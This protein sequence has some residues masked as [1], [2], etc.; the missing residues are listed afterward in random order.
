MLILVYRR[1]LA[2]TNALVATTICL[3]IVLVFTFNEYT[4][5][6]NYNYITPYSHEALHGLLL[7]I[8]TIAFTVQL[9]HKK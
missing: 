5:T 9:V 2:A 3:G 6:G 8:F 4:L 7:S 1:F